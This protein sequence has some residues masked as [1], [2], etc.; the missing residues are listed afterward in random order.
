MKPAPIVS[1]DADTVVRVWFD[2][3]VPDEGV[4]DFGIE[5]AWTVTVTRDAAEDYNWEEIAGGWT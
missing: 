4:P 1:V 5:P 2:E 3:G